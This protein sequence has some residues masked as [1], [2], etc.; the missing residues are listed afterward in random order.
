MAVVQSAI[1]F[2]LHILSTTIAWW[3]DPLMWVLILASQLVYWL[4]PGFKIQPT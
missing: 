1:Q 2:M 3:S 4:V